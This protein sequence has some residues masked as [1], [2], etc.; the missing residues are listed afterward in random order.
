METANAET[1][2]TRR[3]LPPPPVRRV[4]AWCT[5]TRVVWHAGCVFVAPFRFR[6]EMSTETRRLLLDPVDK[7]R[8]SQISEVLDFCA[9]CAAAGAP[10]D[11]P[12]GCEKDVWQSRTFDRWKCPSGW[13]AHAVFM[14]RCCGCGLQRCADFLQCTEWIRLASNTSEIESQEWIWTGQASRACAS[15]R[16]APGGR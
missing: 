13:R 12:F 4:S 2:T 15:Q 3:S 16:A 5:T 7:M 9:R 10:E 6:A 8:L 1:L 11:G 14:C